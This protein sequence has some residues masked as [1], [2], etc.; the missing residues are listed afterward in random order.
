MN[1]EELDIREVCNDEFSDFNIIKMVVKISESTHW[2][3]KDE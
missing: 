3:C 2:R 1:K